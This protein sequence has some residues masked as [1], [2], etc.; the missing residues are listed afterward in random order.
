[1]LNIVSYNCNS[2]RNN[3]DIVKSLFSESDIVMLQEL[4]LEKRDV[5]VLNDFNKDFKHIAFVKDREMEGICEGRPA[6][7]VAIFWRN[8]LSTMISPVFVNDFIIGIVFRSND[9]NVLILNVYMP[10]DLQTLDSFENY[11]ESLAMLEIVI[12]EQNVNHII[13]GGDLNADP[14]KGRFWK[15]LNEFTKSSSLHI[16]NN[17][18]P[19]DTFT[20]LC[21]TKKHYELVRPYNLFK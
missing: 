5:G 9:F 13:I 2:V 21:P 8:H 16:L 15:L 17:I 6:R 7:G 19:L 12:K 11:R 3:V 10:C 20:Y 14:K 4:M 1:M 18:F